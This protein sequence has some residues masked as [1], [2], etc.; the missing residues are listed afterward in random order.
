MTARAGPQSPCRR[1]AICPLGSRPLRACVGQWRW[2]KDRPSGSAPPP[3]DVQGSRGLMI[4]TRSLPVEEQ[5]VEGPPELQG[6]PPR[7]QLGGV[8]PDARSTGRPDDRVHPGDDLGVATAGRRTARRAATL[9]GR[10]HRDGADPAG[11]YRLPW[12]QTEG[13]LRSIF[14]LLGLELSAPDHTTL[15]RRAGGLQV[16]LRRL[17]TTEP[18]H[19]IVDAT[20]LGIVGQGQWAAAKWGERGRRGWRKL[21]IAVDESGR[22]LAAE[23]TDRR[24]AD[25][26]MRRWCKDRI[27]T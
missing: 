4:S 9:L 19:L 11:L 25:A 24:V 12:R 21:H 26:E 7:S 16:E 23:L 2:C 3:S 14:K 13:L 20:G 22:V 1:R 10:G 6:P 5:P 27:G 18:V 15:S 8:R 17:L